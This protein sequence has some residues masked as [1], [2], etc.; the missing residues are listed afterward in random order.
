MSDLLAQ[1]AA[2]PAV[3][4]PQQSHNGQAAAQPPAPD[5]PQPLTMSELVRH[6]M[7]KNL[8][9][10]QE[11]LRAKIESMAGSPPPAQGKPQTPAKSELA[12]TVEQ[13]QARLAE[14]QER[15]ANLEF[16]SGFLQSTA[17][18]KFAS[19]EARNLAMSQ[20]RERFQKREDGSW[21]DAKTGEIKFSK[22]GSSFATMAEI[23]PEFLK[24][25]YPFLLSGGTPV[26]ENGGG[27]PSTPTNYKPSA[28]ELND[29][30]FVAAIG[31]TGQQM[32]MVR[33][34]T[35]DRNLINRHIQGTVA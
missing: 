19:D 35:I 15:S 16:E 5:G 14:M 25:S 8:M 3:E 20:F 9:E 30:A 23:V 21:V 26:G 6:P 4:A 18:L 10:G 32:R 24:A 33:T 17:A 31:A 27:V 1:Q 28:A 2:A 22:N 11:N 29:P 13:L 34:G 7:F 12:E